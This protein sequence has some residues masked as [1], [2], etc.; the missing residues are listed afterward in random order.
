PAKEVTILQQNEKQ[1][2]KGFVPLARGRSQSTRLNHE[3]SQCL[4]MN[5]NNSYSTLF[6][7]INNVDL[8]KNVLP[9]DENDITNISKYEYELSYDEEHLFRC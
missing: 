2:K 6:Q 9:C 8:I 3:K 4:C 7:T 5:C 1:M